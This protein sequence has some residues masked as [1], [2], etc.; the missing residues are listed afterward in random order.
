[1]VD[2]KHPVYN[3]N[4]SNLHGEGR[5]VSLPSQNR[6]NPQHR[7]RL[8]LGSSRFGLVFAAKPG[9]RIMNGPKAKWIV[10]LSASLNLARQR[11]CE[12]VA[13]ALVAEA[14]EAVEVEHPALQM[15]P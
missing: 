15:A 1:M 9:N 14:I 8:T 5:D 7:N 12:L 6:R 11:E 13:A 10:Q 2:T 3:G 4:K